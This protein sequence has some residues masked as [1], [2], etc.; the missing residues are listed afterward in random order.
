M[1]VDLQF[2]VVVA[3]V[4]IQQSIN[5]LFQPGKIIF[6]SPSRPPLGLR[7]NIDEQ[8]RYDRSNLRPWKLR[9][10]IYKPVPTLLILFTASPIISILRTT[11]S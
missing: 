11:A 4:I 2:P 1:A 9:M 8:S 6:D 3:L 10:L 5:L 7:K